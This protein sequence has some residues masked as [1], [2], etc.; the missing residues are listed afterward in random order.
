M[1]LRHIQAELETGR[2]RI[3]PLSQGGRRVVELYLIH[4][5]RDA[6]GPATRQLAD[7]LL[8]GAQGG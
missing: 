7:L 8:H 2:L 5:D 4:R 6:A 1:P 3:L